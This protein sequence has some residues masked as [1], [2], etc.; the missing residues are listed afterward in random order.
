MCTHT[1]QQPSA[2]GKSATPTSSPKVSPKA[3]PKASPGQS[4]HGSPRASPT[5]SRHVRQHS[6]PSIALRST[7]EAGSSGVTSFHH[8]DIT[9]PLVNHSPSRYRAQSG[10]EA[11]R[12]T[13]KSSSDI[14]NGSQLVRSSEVVRQR[15]KE[16][17][18]SS[19]SASTSS[20]SP[21]SSNGDIKLVSL[22]FE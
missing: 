12:L 9:P 18:T 10:G 6:S 11:S 13:V 16:L 8:T 2:V 19:V 14:S 7:T 21:S 1:H 17:R 22:L 20:N 4:P 15:P 3:S 5:P